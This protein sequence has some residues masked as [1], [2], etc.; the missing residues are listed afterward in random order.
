VHFKARE[1]AVLLAVL[2]KQGVMPDPFW[3]RSCHLVL[4]QRLRFMTAR[5]FAMVLWG[6]SQL[7]VPPRD[8]WRDRS[9]S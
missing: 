9:A 2:A 5:D 7:G 1:W 6:I 4:Q 8:L 3:Q